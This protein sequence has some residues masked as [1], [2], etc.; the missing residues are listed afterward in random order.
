MPAKKYTKENTSNLIISLGGTLLGI[1]TSNKRTIFKIKC[2]ICSNIWETRPDIVFGKHKSWCSKCNWNTNTIEK[3]KL[4]IE[5]NGSKL[6]SNKYINNRTILTILC[7]CGH[8]RKINFHDFQNHPLC[9]K[10]C[11]RI[12]NNKLKY[13][14]NKVRNVIELLNGILLTDKKDYK[15]AQQK[16]QVRC[17][18]CNHEWATTF[19]RI[20]PK[21]KYHYWCPNCSLKNKQSKPKYT[22]YILHKVWFLIMVINYFHY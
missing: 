17:N 9:R 10:C 5:L 20:N 3:I 15:N 11:P 18:I 13:S 8:E 16:L 22:Y 2:N 4:K 14:Y 7:A 19:N 6:L 21:N 1:Y 12:K